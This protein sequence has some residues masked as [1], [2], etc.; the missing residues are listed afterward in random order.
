MNVL[1]DTAKFFLIGTPIIYFSILSTTILHELGHSIASKILYNDPINI[2][3]GLIPADLYKQKKTIL[4]IQGI[5]IFSLNPFLGFSHNNK[6]GH[7]YKDIMIGISGPILGITCSFF[8][9]KYYYKKCENLVVNPTQTDFNLSFF[10]LIGCLYNFILQIVYLIPEK[11]GQF[12]TDTYKII[13]L[14]KK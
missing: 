14:L 11:E 13:Q 5:K 12:E 4:K 6:F 2:S 1:L 8:S 9:M 10:I 3:I 7:K